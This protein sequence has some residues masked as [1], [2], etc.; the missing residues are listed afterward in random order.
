MKSFKAKISVDQLTVIAKEFLESA[1]GLELNI[2]ISY[3]GRL[4]SALGRFLEDDEFPHEPL[5]IELSKNLG[6]YHPEHEIIE[7]LKHELVHYAL[8]ILKKPYADGEEYFEKEL[9]RFGISSSELIAYKGMVHIYECAE[10]HAPILSERKLSKFVSEC[11][12]GDLV[13]F[14]T[15]LVTDQQYNTEEDVLS[16]YVSG[17]EKVIV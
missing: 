3:N 2:P 9:E 14:E 11:C 17:K 6:Q 4:T 10:C 15:V 1:Y 12:K 16:V 7:V 5:A 13:F 8:H